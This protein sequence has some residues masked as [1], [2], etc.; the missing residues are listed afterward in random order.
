MLMWS[1]QATGCWLPSRVVTGKPLAD[2][3]RTRIMGNMTQAATT[4]QQ[5][6]T[7]SP[8][9]VDGLP[10]MK[11]GLSREDP[12]EVA[13][14][15]GPWLARQDP[16]AGSTASP[17]EWRAD[18]V[19]RAWWHGLLNEYLTPAGA[20]W[21][22]TAGLDWSTALPLP[23]WEGRLVVMDAVQAVVVLSRASLLA[24]WLS[25]ARRP[26]GWSWSEAVDRTPLC[27]YPIRNEVPSMARQALDD[28]ASID[29]PNR[30]GETPLMDA[31]ARGRFNTIAWLLLNGAD[32]RCTTPARGWSS[33]ASA[34]DLV[35]AR[36]GEGWDP[37]VVLE[38]LDSAAAAW[39]EGRQQTWCLSQEMVAALKQERKTEEWDE[40]TVGQMGWKT[41]DEMAATTVSTQPAA[42]AQTQ[43]QAQHGP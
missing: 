26:R 17:N 25:T 38:T 18:I 40:P 6:K 36:L 14:I 39:D 27:W 15:L 28:G 9:I 37:G 33:G 34:R 30:L 8:L 13:A 4:A 24:D 43:R 10:T 5:Q 19:A 29:T 11:K 21:L 3:N 7:A 12:S 35:P 2:V 23:L 32:P 31:V 20:A 1:W 16:P 41:V 22:R 42:P